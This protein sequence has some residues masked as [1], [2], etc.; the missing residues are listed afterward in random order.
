MPEAIGE[1]Y[2]RA[3]SIPLLKTVGIELRLVF[4]GYWVAARALGFYH[5]ERRMFRT[6][7]YIVGI[8]FPLRIGHPL[9]LNLYTCLA[10]LDVTLFFEHIPSGLA[11][12]Q[13]DKPAPRLSFR[14]IVP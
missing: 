14:D 7:Q 10:G 6:E 11:E 2:H 13:I 12:E 8:P 4:S 1:I 3:H 5:G 9:Y